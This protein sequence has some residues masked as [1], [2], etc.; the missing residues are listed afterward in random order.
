LGKIVGEVELRAVFPK[1]PEGH[2]AFIAELLDANLR[3][4]FAQLFLDQLGQFVWRRIA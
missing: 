3:Q 2:A 4:L 1:F